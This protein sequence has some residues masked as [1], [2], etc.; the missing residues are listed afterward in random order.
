ML[1]ICLQQDL[2]R[3]GFCREKDS[4][5]LFLSFLF[6]FICFVNKT[7][8]DAV[9][10]T[11]AN[12]IDIETEKAIKKM[13]VKQNEVTAL[14]YIRRHYKFMDY[15]FFLF[16]FLF[17]LIFIFLLLLLFWNSI[18]RKSARDNRKISRKKNRKQCVMIMSSNDKFTHSLTRGMNEK[19]INKQ[20]R[21]TKQQ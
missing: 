1:T 16:L 9:T 17:F 8:N 14:K 21:Y 10:S 6:Y 5:L 15:A 20:N 3:F 12:A 11:N 13:D 4:V 19:K 18:L 7:S 2:T